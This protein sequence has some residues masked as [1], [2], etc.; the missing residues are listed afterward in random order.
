[1]L[2][3]NLSPRFGCAVRCHHRSEFRL[4]DVASAQQI[5]ALLQSHIEGD[6]DHFFAVAMQVAAHEAKMGHGKLAEELRDLIDEAKSRRNVLAEKRPTPLAQ[7]KG[8]L[9]G[10]L[11]ASYPKSHLSDMIL[12]EALKHRLERII[13]EH[14]QFT[15]IRAHGLSPRRKLLLVGAPGTGKTMTAG[16]LAGELRLPLLRVKLDALITKYLG[17][18]AAKLRLIF[19]AASATRGV[20]FFDEFDAIAS[21]R[22]LTSDVGEMRR[23]LNSFLQMIEQEDS[24]SLVIAATNHPEILDYAVFRRFDDVLEYKLPTSKEIVGMLK[25]RLGEFAD[26]RIVWETAAGSAESLSYADLARAADESIKDM[27]IHDRTVVTGD[28]LR[29]AFHDR[30]AIHKR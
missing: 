30:R 6:D 18:T 24:N 19:D 27:I 20:Y 22:A 17:E 3:P 21:Q 7:P 16:V 12:D 23:V 2:R 26:P 14:R 10:L 29:R 8:D 25:A 11:D 28:D 15:R 9:A 5:K 4:Q 13:K 1:V